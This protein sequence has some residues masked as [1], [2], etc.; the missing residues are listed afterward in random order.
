MCRKGLLSILWILCWVPSAKGLPDTVRIDA[1]FT[2]SEFPLQ[3]QLFSDVSFEADI[4]FIRN[5]MQSKRDVQFNN[6]PS[7]GYIKAAY[8]FR[9][10]VQNIDKEPQFVILSL[11]NPNIDFVTFYEIDQ[12]GQ[13]QM[14]GVSG[15]HLQHKA[16]WFSSRQP[17]TLLELAP[18]EVKE[19]YV[20]A[21]NE[22][23]GNMLL[24]FR[25]WAGN[26]FQVY[27]Q[28]YHLIW[29]LYFGFV[30]INIALSFSAI[31]LLRASIFIWYGLFLISTLSYTTVS[32]GFTYQY[33]TGDFAGSNDLLRTYSLLFLS[34]FMLRFSQQFLQTKALS[35]NLHYLIGIIISIQASF[36]L[37]SFFI[38]STFRDNFNVLFPWMLVLIMTGY[39]IL[40]YAAYVNRRKTELRSYGFI[41]AFGFTILGGITLILTDLNVLPFNMFTIHAPWIGNAIE[42][43]IFTGILLYEFKLI[44]D[45]KVVLE[46]QIAQEQ[47]NRLKE[48]F[49]G[50][51]RERE[52]ISRDL[53][54]NVAGSLVGAR[55]LLPKAEQLA[56]QLDEA[57]FLSYQR[58]LHTLDRSIHDVRNLS[59]NLQP[60]SLDETTLK[61]E[62]NR[63]VL[64]HKSMVPTADFDF[65]YNIPA[66]KLNNDTAIAIYRVIQECLLNIFKH[67]QA[68]HVKLLVKYQ[69]G[70]VSLHIA[71]DGVGF[72]SMNQTGGIGLQNVRSRLAF[73]S[74]LE[75]K[76]DSSPG[77]GT[78]ISISFDAQA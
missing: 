72:N 13:A 32:F 51:E 2:K 42:I 1:Q 47:T 14:A 69:H 45:K 65:D 28:G 5:I 9:F 59:H 19:I 4:N 43:L 73:T 66:G 68:N 40:I 67:A 50:Q 62:L 53:H 18:G 49:R 17:A 74:N 11:E 39:F 78:Q 55:F 44:G 20:Q 56:N 34:I 21:K 54:D 36:L 63:L 57:A 27:Q 46:Q 23:S 33:I 15:D 16:W 26:H 24:P 22:H 30:L 31:F 7:F 48:F 52:R 71:D 60:P 29:G 61:Y 8:W 58:A 10:V 77:L 35:Y 3:T 12:N 70:R 75:T 6:G 38:R 64:D 25:I 37:L 41:L 76:I